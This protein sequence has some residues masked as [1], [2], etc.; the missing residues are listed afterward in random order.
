[1]VRKEKITIVGAGPVGCFMAILLAKRGFQVTVYERK[2]K[3]EFQNPSSHLSYHITFYSRGVNALK[4]AGVWDELKKNAVP[5]DGTV[6]HPLYAQ[7]S[8]SRLR[9]KD[10]LYFAVQRCELL[11]ILMKEAKKYP[12]IQ[13][14]FNRKFINV[15]HYER[16]IV[17]QNMHNNNY[18]TIP[19]AIV[20]GADGINSRVRS[21]IQ[22]GQPVEYTQIYETWGYKHVLF[23]KDLVTSL[24]LRNHAMHVWPRKNVILVAFPNSNGSLTGMLVLPQKQDERYTRL[25]SKTDIQSFIK[26]N[27]PDL[28][29][30]TDE[31]VHSIRDNPEGTLS[32]VYTAPWYYKDFLVLIGDAAHG[33]VPFYGQGTTAG[34]EDCLAF[35]S[36]VDTYKTDWSKIFPEYQYKRKRHTD[37]LA[38][39]SRDNFKQFRRHKEADYNAIHSHLEMILH[40]L[41]PSFWIYPLYMLMVADN[42]NFADILEKHKKQKKK[43][44]F[45][46]VSLVALLLTGV[47]E[48]KSK[49]RFLKNK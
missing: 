41:F 12:N 19:S 49:L 21:N 3:E 26:S 40:R 8:F 17:I 47:I 25:D 22:I 48:A 14:H 10:T 46:G 35:I 28:A 31:I 34:F 24:G 43:A 42:D 7:A 2:A 11:K 27:F 44:L 15:S 20:I 30:A 38:N 18:E 36:L 33:T 4:K 5:L 1:M 32:T 9:K 39:L 45:T 29:L 23:N 16:S 6:V 13:F 37:V